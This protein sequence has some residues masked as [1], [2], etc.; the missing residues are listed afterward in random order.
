VLRNPP[1]TGLDR[2]AKKIIGGGGSS[3]EP[4]EILVLSK[5]EFRGRHTEK[6]H[7]VTFIQNKNSTFRENL[8]REVQPSSQVLQTQDVRV[9]IITAK[10]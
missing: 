2:V 5:E 10:R 1:L 6:F 3:L 8:G 4:S 9:S 7:T